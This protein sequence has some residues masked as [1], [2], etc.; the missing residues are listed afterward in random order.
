MSMLSS[1]VYTARGRTV[2]LEL[3]QEPQVILEEQ[4][5]AVNAVEDH[6]HPVKSKAKCPA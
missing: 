4:G 2:I 5:E 6:R 3:P 1:G